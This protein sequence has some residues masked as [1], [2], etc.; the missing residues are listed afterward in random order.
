MNS[1]ENILQKE[2]E[3]V[4][5]RLEVLSPDLHFSVGASSESYSR[6]EI[7]KQ[8]HENTDVGLDFIK[9]ELEFLRAIKD[10]S[11]ISSL[12]TI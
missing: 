6:D 2:K 3:L 10:G 8:I 7:I 11:L 12:A 5:A 1:K 9:V 4:L